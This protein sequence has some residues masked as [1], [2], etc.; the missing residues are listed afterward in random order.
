MLRKMDIFNVEA[1]FLGTGSSHGVPVIGCP[2]P[3]CQSDD[4]RDK[5]MRS[6]L[7]LKYGSLSLLI[8]T[9][10]DLRH[11]LLCY[12]TGPLDAVLLTHEHNDHIVG[13][14]DLRP[15]NYF[16]T[17]PLKVYGTSA[18]KKALDQR[19]DYIFGEAPYPGAL[20]VDFEEMDPDATWWM[21]GHP[22]VPIRVW[23]GKMPVLGFRFGEFAYVTDAKVIPEESM[24]KLEGVQ[25]LVLNALHFTGH[26]V[27]LNVEEALAIINRIQPEKAFLTHISHFMGFHEEVN[28][29]LPDGVEL[30]YDGL[31]VR[32]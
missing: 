25:V 17:G 2:C 1:T 10:P 32:V 15:Y 3:V 12:P 13:F 6:A 8:D 18:V 7:A 31:V 24:Q 9:G 20:K 30:A 14:D 19:F 29:M 5:R 23:H 11:Q 26:H 22:I 21:D 27:H 4:L 28:K 16:Q